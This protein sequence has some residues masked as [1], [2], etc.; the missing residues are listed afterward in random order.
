VVPTDRDKRCPCGSGETYPACCGRFHRA[1][2]V[3]ATAEVLMRSRYSAFAV[4][5]AAYLHDTWDVSSRPTEI[6]LDDAISWTSLEIIDTVRGGP[7][8]VEGVVEFRAHYRSPRGRGDRH[9]RSRF[10]KQAGRWVYLSGDTY[11]S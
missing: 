3:P 2:A 9:E 4:G 7:F 5:D 10:A 11:A 6:E 8:D 1:T